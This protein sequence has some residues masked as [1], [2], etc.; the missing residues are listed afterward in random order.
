ML[1]GGGD[2]VS[3]IYVVTPLGLV[4]VLNFGYFSSFSSYYKPSNYYFSIALLEHYK[5]KSISRIR[6]EGT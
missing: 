5:L 2:N 3:I 4:S 1:G 6:G